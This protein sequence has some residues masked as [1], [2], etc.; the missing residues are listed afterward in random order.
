MPL[1]TLAPVTKVPNRITYFDQESGCQLT[2]EFLEIGPE[3]AAEM[4]KANPDNRSLSPITVDAYVRA[5]TNG[6]WRHVSDP[7]RLNR[8]NEVLD[9]GHRLTAI[10]KSGTTHTFMVVRGIP[11]E[12]RKVM[13]QGRPRTTRDNLAMLGI[14]N[15]N[16]KATIASLLIRWEMGDPSNNRVKIQNQQG[17]DY[18]LANDHA[19]T[20]AYAQ[21]RAAKVAIGLSIG[22][23]GAVFYKANAIDVFQANEFFNGLV[24]GAGVDAGSPILTV[25]NAIIR[26]KQ[27][28]RTSRR[29]ITTPEELYYI[30][31]AWNGFRSGEYLTKVQ[32]PAS[33]LNAA[34]FVMK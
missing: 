24:T 5:M 3:L 28:D 13:D 18:V 16:A 27:A 23:G 12:H 20:R 31:R 9:G 6:E 33:G 1:K 8:D 22:T 34:N 17:T 10:V 14:T 26:I 29:R 30:V 25:R 21:A 2:A 15:H 19:L 7:I 11:T 4:L 32:L